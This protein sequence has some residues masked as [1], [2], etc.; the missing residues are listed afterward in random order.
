[1]KLA[2]TMFTILAASATAAELQ[3]GFVATE[4][5]PFPIVVDFNRDGLDD[6]V[7]E[8]S[9]LLNTGGGFGPARMFGFPSSE[10]VI[11]A[12]DVNGDGRPDL[13]TEWATSPVPAPLPQ[14]AMGRGWKL[15]LADSSGEFG[16]GVRIQRNAR[17]YPADVDADGK[18]D[19][20]FTEEIYDGPRAIGTNVVVLRSRGDG[21]FET[22]D[23]VRIPAYAQMP[24][25]RAL[26]GDLN[27]DG[28]P[29]LVIRSVEA[30]VVLL[31]TGGGHFE[32]RS[33]YLPLNQDFGGSSARLG[34]IDG[35]AHLDVILT[36]FRTVR[37]LF[38]DGRGSFPRSAR[39]RLEKLHG[40]IGYPA[41]LPIDTDQI[42]A[43]RNVALGH[44][45][46]RDQL[47]IAA[48][49]TEGDIVVFSYERGALREVSR[50][51]TEFWLIELRSGSFNRAGGT[52]LYAMGT[53]IWGDVWP[54]PRLFH[55]GEPAAGE[56]SSISVGR[57]RAIGGAP[58]TQLRM[59]IGGTC[60][61][62]RTDVWA[63]ERE[64]VFGRAEKS[65]T[66]ID[67][68]FVDSQLYFRLTAPWA[69][70][71]VYGTLT[72]AGGTYSGTASV[73]TDCGWQTLN[74]TAQKE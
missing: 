9:L 33:R 2:I 61:A 28:R 72:D 1:M 51:L 14:P 67:A 48:G 47:Q 64:G 57:R 42:N 65:D 17:P 20:V 10:R 4:G 41:G 11:A 68:V 49:T 26:T 15:Y 34:D 25:D 70:E 21:S 8:R 43:P 53:L 23:P 73:P 74:I 45:T 36:G 5:A 31:G 12:P 69:A 55:G 3:P 16:Q 35:D 60:F 13:I 44:Y 54:R 71:A 6:L 19:L 62:E 22:L 37:V 18:D 39:A 40:M 56:E 66:S 46:R 32:A 30:L 58:V 29:D 27:H 38:G 50:T 24:P 63:F 52:D 7:Q 59:Q